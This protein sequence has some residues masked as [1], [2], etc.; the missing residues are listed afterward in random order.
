MDRSDIY[1]V[2]MEIENL[3]TAPR[4]KVAPGLRRIQIECLARKLR[5]QLEPGL[6]PDDFSDPPRTPITKGFE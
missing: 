4:W 2:V 6:A 1:K 3:C 5:L